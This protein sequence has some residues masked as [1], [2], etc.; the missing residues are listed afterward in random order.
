M[1][2]LPFLQVQQ[3][4]PQSRSAFTLVSSMVVKMKAN[5]TDAPYVFERS[6]HTQWHFTLA[7]AQLSALMPVAHQYL[8]ACRLPYEERN[9]AL[10]VPFHS[11]ICRANCVSLRPE[12]RPSNG[13]NQGAAR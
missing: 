9:E 4:E 1:C 3:L 10:Q 12:K 6:K 8:A 2:R 13:S 11:C 5:M 7:Y